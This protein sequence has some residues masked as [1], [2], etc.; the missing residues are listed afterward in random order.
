[1]KNLNTLTIVLALLAIPLYAA[2]AQGNYS[3]AVSCTIPSVPGLNAP[4]IEEKTV[5][6]T[7]TQE[8]ANLQTETKKA[9]KIEAPVMIQEDTKQDAKL[10]TTIYSR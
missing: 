4:L 5:K 9:P 7:P 3:L 10:I 1:M 6:A 8:N 2:Y